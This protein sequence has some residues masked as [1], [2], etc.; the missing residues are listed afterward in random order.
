[1]MQ[2][3]IFQET[4]LSNTLETFAPKHPK[5]VYFQD[6]NSSTRIYQNYKKLDQ[7]IKNKWGERGDLESLEMMKI[8][9]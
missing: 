4:G 1:M 3:F 9:L 7:E 2:D 8:K 6:S 5:L